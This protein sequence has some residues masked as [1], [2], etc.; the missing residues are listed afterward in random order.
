MTKQGLIVRFV[1]IIPNQVFINMHDES[2][3]Q[4]KGSFKIHPFLLT[5]MIFISDSKDV[6]TASFEDVTD[7]T[8]KQHNN[9]GSFEGIIDITLAK[10]KPLE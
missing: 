3:Q 2:N 6:A 9:N 7:E 4:S 5:F 1:K 8:L 10:H